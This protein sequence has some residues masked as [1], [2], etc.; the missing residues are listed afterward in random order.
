[1]LLRELWEQPAGRR[2]WAR[3]FRNEPAAKDLA[4]QLGWVATVNADAAIP[5]YDLAWMIEQGVLWELQRYQRTTSTNGQISLMPQTGHALGWFVEQAPGRVAG[6][7][8][9]RIRDADAILEIPAEVVEKS[10][11]NSLMLDGGMTEA[12]VERP[13]V[14]RRPQPPQQGAGGQD[15]RGRREA[16]AHAGA[17]LPCGW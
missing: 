2:R 9:A 3:P 10:L 15:D 6:L 12:R 4:Q 7:L 8:G 17:S 5:V 1:M 16:S 14:R 13:R 11:R